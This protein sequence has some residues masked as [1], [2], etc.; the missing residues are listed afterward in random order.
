MFLIQPLISCKET[1]CILW[2]NSTCSTELESPKLSQ[3]VHAAAANLALKTIFLSCLKCTHPTARKIKTL[4]NFL[5]V[6]NFLQ[7]KDR[8][9]SA[10]KEIE[11][12]GRAAKAKDLFYKTN[13]S[14]QDKDSVEDTKVKE[15]HDHERLFL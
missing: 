14:T 4:C 10:P 6:V 15:E 5:Y 8:L 9:I 1:S 7:W 3:G 12:G 11:G 2:K 13:G